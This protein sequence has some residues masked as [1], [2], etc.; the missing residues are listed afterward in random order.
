LVRELTVFGHRMIVRIRT[1]AEI[2]IEQLEALFA[3]LR[4][5]I[6]T[7]AWRK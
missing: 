5:F 6:S 7:R 3:D 1:D 2:T 4:A